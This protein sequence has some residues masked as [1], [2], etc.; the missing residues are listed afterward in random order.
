MKTIYLDYAATCPC[1]PVVVEAMR[2]YFFEHFG[3]TLSPHAFGRRARKATEGAREELALLLNAKPQEIVFTSSATESNNAAIYS[4]VHAL[5]YKGNHLIISAIE[6]HSILEPVKRLKLEGYEISYVPVEND[7]TIAVG[8]VASLIR[9]DTILAAVGHANNEIGVIQSIDAIGKIL[10]EKDV[11][12]LVDAVQ[13]VGHVPVDV[14][15]IQADFLSLSAHKFYGPQGVGALFV[16][17]GV[18]FEPS[19]LGGDQER[20]RR[21]G[22]LNVPGIVGLGEAARLA[23]EQMSSEGIIQA[24]MRDVIIKAVMQETPGSVLNGHPQQRLPNN[25]HFSFEGVNGEE[26]IASLDMVGICCSMGSACTSG[27]LEPSHVLKAIGLSD[28]LALSSLRVSL[29]RFT[30]PDDAEY[31]LEQINKKVKQLCSSK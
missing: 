13:T 17:Q 15:A 28:P 9:P 20:S 8:M 18:V 21:A 29:G 6:H 2:P 30:T 3:N 4:T 27:Q 12:F 1:D 31:F 11:Y 23:R 5:R 22:T 26:L 7:G 25:A 19:V 16:R 14:K 24:A 10:R